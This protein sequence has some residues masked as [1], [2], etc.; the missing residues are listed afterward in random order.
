MSSGVTTVVMPGEAGLSTVSRFDR[1]VHV[2]LRELSW[3]QQLG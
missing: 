3:S 1:T 2:S